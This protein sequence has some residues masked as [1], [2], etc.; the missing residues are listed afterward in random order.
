MLFGNA[1][2]Q[3]IFN[4]IK[5][6]LSTEHIPSESELVLRLRNILNIAFQDSMQR[7]SLWMARPKYYTMLHEIYYDGS[8]PAEKVNDIQDRLDVCIKNF[9]NSKT[10]TDIVNKANEI[11]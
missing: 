7:R 2:H 3:I 6:Y 11:R 8:L 9:F 10:F 4:V 1:V 5:Q